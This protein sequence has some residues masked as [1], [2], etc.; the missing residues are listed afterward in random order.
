LEEPLTKEQLQL[1]IQN[2][3]KEGR[4]ST[5]NVNEVKGKDEKEIVTK[6]KV[7][8]EIKFLY[9]H[10]P[11]HHNE[12]GLFLQLLKVK[13][14]LTTYTN[15]QN[16]PVNID[17]RCISVGMGEE[18]ERTL[19]AKEKPE[20]GSTHSA[21][22]QDS[23]KILPEYVNQRLNKGEEAVKITAESDESSKKLLKLYNDE[24]KVTNILVKNHF[25]KHYSGSRFIQR[26]KK[27][28]RK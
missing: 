19:A 12:N 1:F 23:E 21:P 11:G 22:V 7:T 18:F 6:E 2:M 24:I 16:M 9:L 26:K 25:E 15:E 3:Q 4:H 20:R 17:V 28:R 10:A 8:K 14:S 5:Q 13:T 27:L